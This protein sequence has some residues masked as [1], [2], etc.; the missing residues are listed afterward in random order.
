LIVLEILLGGGKIN[1]PLPVKNFSPTFSA[2]VHRVRA[3]FSQLPETDT[4]ENAE[5]ARQKYGPLR[6]CA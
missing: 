5:S 3:F 4:P 2:G 6:R 1:F